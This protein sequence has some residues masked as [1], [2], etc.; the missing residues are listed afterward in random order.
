MRNG[1]WTPAED[2][3]LREGAEHKWSITK[4]LARLPGRNRKAITDRACRV[5]I[6]LRLSDSAFVANG[7]SAPWTAEEDAKL[8]PFIRKGMSRQQA[9]R[10]IKLPGRTSRAVEARYRRLREAQAGSYPIRYKESALTVD[11]TPT[12]LS[13]FPAVEKGADP[14]HTKLIAL[15]RR[16]AEQHAT[17][18]TTAMIGLNFGHQA[19]A[20]FAAQQAVAA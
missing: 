4:L 11:R 8:I 18:V 3:I 12:A 9:A 16:Q 1:I 5:R 2:A 6:P 15:F 14:L 19:A 10:H 20:R 13:G 17:D 7:S